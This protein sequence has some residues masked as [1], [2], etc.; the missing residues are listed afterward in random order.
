MR[1][2]AS[3]R[4]PLNKKCAHP[5]CAEPTADPHH[6][7]PRSQII[8]DSWFVEITESDGQV[9][10]PIPHVT[11]LCRAHHEDVEQ[12]RAWIRLEDGN[13]RWWDRVAAPE[14][15]CDDHWKMLGPLNPQ[16]GSVES[17][18]KRRKYQGEERRQ[19]KT[20]SIRVPQDS[21]ENG[22]EVWDTLL[23]QAQ[24]KLQADMDVSYVP[25]P[26]ITLIAVLHDYIT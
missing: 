4:Y 9:T 11:G 6:A 15:L 24:E 25:T 10:L 20:I 19:R 7:F 1:G 23:E 18:P 26:Y 5:E 2:V 8:G 14:A 17:K 13:F 22:G 3:E 12:H 21:V 16:P